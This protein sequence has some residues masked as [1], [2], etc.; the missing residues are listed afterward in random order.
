VSDRR[1]RTSDRPVDQSI[2]RPTAE[3]LL[4]R[5]VRKP[6]DAAASITSLSDHA[7]QDSEGA[8][9]LGCFGFLRG[10]RDRALMLELRKKDGST[11]AIAYA[12]IE[13]ITYHPDPPNDGITIHA[14]GQKFRITGHNLNTESDN[15]VRLFGALARHRVP[16]I[17]ERTSPDSSDRAVSIESIVG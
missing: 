16:W 9:D 5:Y 13:R 6:G 11:T 14:A 2:D 4:D 7:A 1:E 17:A 3:S 12:F 15:G 10:V 8:E